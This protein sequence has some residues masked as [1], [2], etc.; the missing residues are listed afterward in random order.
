MG[1][2]PFFFGNE[3]TGVEAIVFGALATTVLTKS[4]KVT[5]RS[6]KARRDRLLSADLD[7]LGSQ[8]V[9]QRLDHADGRRP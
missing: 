4:R 8:Q 3:P 5:L 2:G 1:D 7:R 9:T 6:I